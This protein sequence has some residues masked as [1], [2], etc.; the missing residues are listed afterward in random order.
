MIYTN[1]H[2]QLPIANGK[3]SLTD[4]GGVGGDVYGFVDDLAIGGFIDSY[5]LFFC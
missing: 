5:S 2:Q 4:P 1:I 3:V